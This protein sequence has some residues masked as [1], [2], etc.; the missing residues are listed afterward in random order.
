[1]NDVKH[2]DPLD[3]I[4]RFWEKNVCGE[5]YLDGEEQGSHAYF[6]RVTRERYRWHYHLP[7]FL[8][9][10]AAHS[11][12]VL[13]VGCG[14]GID[15]SELARRGADV[16]AVDLTEAGIGLARKN[17]DRLGLGGEFKVSNAEDLDFPDDSFDALFSFGVLH[18]TPNTDQAL[19]EVWRVLKPGGTA[20]IML[21]SRHSLNRW[22]HQLLG[23]GFENS[24]EDRDDAPVTRFYSRRE[25]DELFRSFERC[26][27]RKRYLF[28]AGYRPVAY[29]VPRF[30]NDALGRA[31]G[32]HWLITARKPA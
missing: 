2:T 23:R 31:L 13:E 29:F 22:V 16:T 15:A 26:T 1:M 17:F 7:P 5:L 12:K 21:Y 3:G 28:G 19:S 25:L 32:W 14:M 6:D 27:F 9:E 8:D 30:L 20:Y 4:R 11:G 24:G 10:V 18:H